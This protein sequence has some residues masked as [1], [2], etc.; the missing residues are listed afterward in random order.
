MNSLTES[1]YSLKRA[2]FPGYYL[3][4]MNNSDIRWYW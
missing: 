1:Y 3:T 4:S 2:K